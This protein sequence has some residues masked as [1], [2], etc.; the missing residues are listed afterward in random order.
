LCINKADKD[1]L[2]NPDTLPED[3]Y[4][5]QWFFKG[6]TVDNPTTNDPSNASSQRP[7]IDVS[8]KASGNVH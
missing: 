5:T 7:S 4:I 1:I 8:T 6:I 2:L 3:I